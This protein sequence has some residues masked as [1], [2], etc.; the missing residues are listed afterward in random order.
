[1]EVS[2]SAHPKIEK[3]LN[4]TNTQQFYEANDSYNNIY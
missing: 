3:C 1:M 4:A 2:T